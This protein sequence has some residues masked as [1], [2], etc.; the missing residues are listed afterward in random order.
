MHSEKKGFVLKKMRKWNR[1]KVVEWDII[2]PV[3]RNSKFDLQHNP[4]CRHGLDYHS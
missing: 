2:C 4:S 3:L 1:E